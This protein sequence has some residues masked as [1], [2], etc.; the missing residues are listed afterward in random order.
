[1]CASTSARPCRGYSDLRLD[2]GRDGTRGLHASSAGVVTGWYCCRGGADP[3][4]ERNGDATRA[5]FCA[6]RRTCRDPNYRP[7]ADALHAPAS[8]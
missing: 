3:A 5:P 1:M 7:N 4:A 6:W 8:R 2:V